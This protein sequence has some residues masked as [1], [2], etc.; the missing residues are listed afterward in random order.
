MQIQILQMVRWIITFTYIFNN[1]IVLKVGAEPQNK[2]KPA[3][4]SPSSHSLAR[5]Y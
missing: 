1:K 4:P 3:V 2:P 5:L